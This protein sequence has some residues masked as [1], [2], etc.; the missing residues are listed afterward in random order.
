M[1]HQPAKPFIA[2]DI[3][4]GERGKIRASQWQI[5][6]ALMWPMSVII[7]NEF[8]DKVIQMLLAQHHKMVQA[9]VF[10]RLYKSLAISVQI[11]TSDGQSDDCRALGFKNQIELAD[12]FTVTISD[13][14]RDGQALFIKTNTKISSLLSH[15]L[16]RGMRCGRRDPNPSAIDMNKGQDKV[17]NEAT[18]GPDFLGQEIAGVQGFCVSLNELIPCANAPLR[19]WVVALLFEDILDG[20]AS[21]LAQPQLLQLAQN[22]ATPGSPPIQFLLLGEERIAEHPTG[23]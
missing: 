17:L 16:A 1:L 21:N 18:F 12:K 13:Q 7:G 6:F 23:F 8:V 20:G 3:A 22:T 14:M 9:F 11:R 10:E 4:F 2:M 19:S 5:S 15:P